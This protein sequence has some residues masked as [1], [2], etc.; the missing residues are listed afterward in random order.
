LLGRLSGAP[1]AMLTGQARARRRGGAAAV[2]YLVPEFPGQTHAFFWRE[3]QAL[4]ALGREVQPISTRRPPAETRA[5]HAW[6]AGA[7]DATV[8]LFPLTPSEL[9]SAA[10]EA[11]RAGPPGWGRCLSALLGGQGSSKELVPAVVLGAHLAAVARRRGLKHVHVHSLANAA[12]VALFANRL[13]GLTYSLTLHGPLDYF[14]PNQPLK[15]RHARFG[16]VITE[17]LRREL[18][19]RVG[20]DLPPLRVAPMGVSVER[21]RRSCAYPLREPGQPL[22]V[23]SCSRLNP[24]KRV[25]DLIE[26]AALLRDRGLRVDLAV[27]GAD[28][29]EGVPYQ[30]TLEALIARLG[31]QERVTLLGSLPEDGVVAQLERAH[32]FALASAEEALGVAIMEA[33]AM[34]LPVVVTR[35]GGVAEL[36]EDGQ[37]GY[38]VDPRAPEQLADALWRLSEEPAGCEAMGVRGRARVEQRFHSGVSAR[39][40]HEWL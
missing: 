20:G 2:G 30:R 3:V 19:E 38:A 12:N 5:R 13:A 24:G 4:R 7:A 1:F 25:E 27:G 34:G 29:R 32:V 15:W 18:L 37:H 21:F 28:E 22:R 26:A 33:M 23:F 6:A 17:V 35:V 9:L 11:L 40:L 10:G 36:V 8:Y 16:V 39:A 14:G 31:L